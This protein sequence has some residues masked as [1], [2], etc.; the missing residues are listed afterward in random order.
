M[1]PQEIALVQTTFKSVIP[2][3]DVAADLF[4]NKLFELD[5]ALRTLFKGDIKE[6]GKKLM[7]T[8]GVA[9]SGLT[10]LETIIPTVQKLGADHAGFGVK[11]K[12]YMTV[13]KA[14]L[15]TLEQGLGDAF[16]PDVKAAW[17]EAYMTLSG[18][19]I[20]AAKDV[21]IHDEF[22]ALMA[23]ALSKMNDGSL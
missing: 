1:T 20:D 13:A 15:W 21:G 4:Y 10:N 7:A 22:K 2:I 3:K 14:L 6:Q 17:T 8:L 5:P 23:Q 11:E 12:D 16:T 18:V 19:M 9:V